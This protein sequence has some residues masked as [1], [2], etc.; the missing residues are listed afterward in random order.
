[1]VSECRFEQVT[2]GVKREERQF[3]AILQ[4]HDHQESASSAVSSRG[5]PIDRLAETKLMYIIIRSK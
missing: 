1:M 5:E 4:T 2:G 3:V